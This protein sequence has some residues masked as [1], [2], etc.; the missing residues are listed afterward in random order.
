MTESNLSSDGSRWAFLPTALS[1]P[2]AALLVLIFVAILFP[3][4][5][6][7][8]R[9]A[10]EISRVSGARV[11]VSNLAPALTARGPVLRARDVTIEHPA[12]DQVRLY[13]LEIAPRF[14]TS[15]FG[16]Q[17][18]L[19][20]W[21]QS[22]LG[23][24]DG[25]LRLGGE[26]TFVGS[27]SEV[28]LARLPL[29][30]DSSGVRFEGTLSVDADVALDPNGTLRGMLVFESQS[31]RMQ[32]D[33]LPLEIRFT[34]AKGTIEILESGATRIDSVVVKG[35]LVEAELSGEIGLV[36]LS[37]SPPIDF[38]AHIRIVDATLRRLAP[39]AGLMLSSSGEADVRVSGTL[40]A[41]DIVPIE[42]GTRR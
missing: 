37:Q 9:I 28:E 35:E 25:V 26:P 23:N 41:P 21:A 22:G 10:W 14:S 40:D 31:L 30:L 20:L 29:R 19:R 33:Q 24:A 36:H 38:T 12:I 42:V 8:R 15:W 16:G 4:D 17:P 27:V 39:G 32:T 3:W 5:S 34:H 18:T 11:D 2:L 6:L 13:E 1:I 7:G